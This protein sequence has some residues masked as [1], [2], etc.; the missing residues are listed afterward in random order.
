VRE[1]ASLPSG[2]LSFCAGSS[3][4]RGLTLPARFAIIRANFSVSHSAKMRDTKS[5]PLFRNLPQGRTIDAREHHPQ[6]AS[7]TGMTLQP[8][9]RKA[10]KN[11]L[12]S[13]L[14]PRNSMGE[15][16]ANNDAI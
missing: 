12:K 4:Q 7:R 9:A 14:A 1:S 16:K 6:N 2:R 13:T 15:Y 10:A 11:K 8:A 3:A 5:Y